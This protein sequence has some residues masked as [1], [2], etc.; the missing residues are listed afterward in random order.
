MPEKPR[1]AK[2]RKD[3]STRRTRRAQP[4]PAAEPVQQPAPAPSS[5]PTPAQGDAAGGEAA[6]KPTR[7]TGPRPDRETIRRAVAEAVRSLLGPK[8]ATIAD[9]DKSPIPQPAG[10]LERWNLINA[11][12]DALALGRCLETLFSV[13]GLTFGQFITAV[14]A[15]WDLPEA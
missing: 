10:S 4:D 3:S 6:P 13:K 7:P 11:V 1:P 5:S 12:E 9:T 8:G 2:S 15:R 14:E